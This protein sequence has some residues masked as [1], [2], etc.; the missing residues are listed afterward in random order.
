MGAEVLT[1]IAQMGLRDD[2]GIRTSDKRIGET[3]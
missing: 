2:F 3:E 1:R